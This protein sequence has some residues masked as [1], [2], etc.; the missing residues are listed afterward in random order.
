MSISTR[1]L[2]STTR[3]KTLAGRLRALPVETTP[4]LSP[5]PAEAPRPRPARPETSAVPLPPDLHAAAERFAELFAASAFETW[6]HGGPSPEGACDPLNPTPE[7]L[8]ARSHYRAAMRAVPVLLSPLVVHVCCLGLP[9]GQWAAE[10]NL[11]RADAERALRRA[12]THLLNHFC[13]QT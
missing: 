13:A 3:S 6:V 12:L 5:R 1:G 2:R 7:A 8:L 11:P 10:K 9:L 4:L